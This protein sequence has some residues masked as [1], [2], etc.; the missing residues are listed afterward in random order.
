MLCLLRRSLFSVSLLVIYYV[1][2]Y[3]ANPFLINDLKFDLRIYVCVT[4]FDPLR[5]Y[6]YDEGLARFSTHKYAVLCDLLFV[7]GY[8][9]V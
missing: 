9:L 5:V 4:S 8:V 7:I 6:I 3:I 1:N 2:R